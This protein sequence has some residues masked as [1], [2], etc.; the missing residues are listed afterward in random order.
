MNYVAKLEIFG[1][2]G[3]IQQAPRFAMYFAVHGEIVWRCNKIVVVAD[4]TALT[5]EVDR[6]LAKKLTQNIVR[7]GSAI[8]T[9]N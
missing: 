2:K 6:H 8:H 7:L 3:S 9:S 4:L 1:A 5:M